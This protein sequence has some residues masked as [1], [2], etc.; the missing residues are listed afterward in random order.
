MENVLKIKNPSLRNQF[1]ATWQEQ[2][3]GLDYA[4]LKGFFEDIEELNLHADL[5]LVIRKK[6]LHAWEKRLASIPGLR[7]CH[8]QQNHFVSWV[9]L[10]FED[11]SFLEIDL[12]HG[13]QRRGR[14]FMDV[15]EILD[16]AQKDPKGVRRASIE[17]SFEFALF[18]YHL[19]H[20]ALP[21]KYVE[22]FQSLEEEQRHSILKYLKNRW[23]LP[24]T[25]LISLPDLSLH[26]GLVQKQMRRIS[27]N[28]G[29]K[30]LINRWRNFHNAI[31]RNGMT[32]SFSGVDG[33]GKTTV[34]TAIEDLLWEKYRKDIKK[35][36][37]RPS[38]LP[39]LSA[40]KYGK[41]EAEKR[42]ATTLPRQGKNKN[43][44]SSLVRF[45]YYFA[46]YMF[47]QWWV[48]L[49]HTKQSRTILYDR[50]Y[51][52]FIADSKRS[53]IRLSPKFIRG[54][55]RWVFSPQ[56]NIML[57]AR[58]SVILARKQEL[59]EDDIIELTDKY[60]VLFSKLQQKEP[61]NIYL[62]INNEDLDTT[63]RRIE[64]A[65]VDLI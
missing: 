26:Q 53:N 49:T 27:A 46:D 23:E 19:N 9:E 38:I 59:S 17:H 20:S 60:R 24:Y 42:A 36:R 2:T 54:L 10:Y 35:L 63:L 55:Y 7:K 12:I 31:R 18:F 33:A 61:Q 64:E 5:D 43:P 22:E 29:L 30:G 34:M 62:C 14:V 57:Y 39:I 1:L 65:Y 44:L 41:E 13:I 3:K 52:D 6:D 51:F 4:L 37:Q 58:P 48:Y 50:Y 25:D 56:L 15:E 8:I 11:F 40:Y 28:R 32:I 47:G 21:Q 45:A 16:K